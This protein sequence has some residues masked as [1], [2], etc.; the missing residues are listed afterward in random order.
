MRLEER[1]RERERER[2]LAVKFLRLR[3]HVPLKAAAWGDARA[4]LR[5]AG[6]RAALLESRD[7]DEGVGGK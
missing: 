3:K 4:N 2:D 7:E 6:G 1:E 5:P